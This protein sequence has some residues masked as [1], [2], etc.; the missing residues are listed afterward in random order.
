MQETF[1]IILKL[2][3]FFFFKNGKIPEKHENGSVN[4]LSATITS[5]GLEIDG[6]FCLNFKN[7]LLLLLIIK[8]NNIEKYICESVLSPIKPFFMGK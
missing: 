5:N 4:G 1:S 8:Y 6:E 7:N 3:V 2:I